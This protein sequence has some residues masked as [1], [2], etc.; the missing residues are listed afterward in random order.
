MNKIKSLV[1]GL[2]KVGLHYDLPNF[3]TCLSHCNSLNIHRKFE[4]VGGVDTNKNSRN[5]FENKFRK[6]SFKNIKYAIQ[7]IRPNLIILSTPTIKH[8]ENIKEIIQN[9][10][11][12]LKYLVLEKPLSYSFYEAKEI[13]KICNQNKV[14]FFINYPYMHETFLKKIKL[15]IK[16]NIN[17]QP[18]INLTYSKG[19]HHIG[20]HLLKILIYFLGKPSKIIKINSEKNFDDFYFQ[21]I[22]KF[23]KI[24]VY[25]NY[26]KNINVANIEII[27]SKGQIIIDLNSL[28]IWKRL[29]FKKLDLNNYNVL[30][31]KFHIIKNSLNNAQFHYYNFLSKSLKHKKIIKSN[32]DEFFIEKL[33]FKIKN[34]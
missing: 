18:I 4:L 32:N 12:E 21:G 27:N 7:K 22:L 9:K 5:I 29:K 11:K 24:K 13:L 8:L 34:I 19:M 1:I 15:I 20:S 3:D 14:K 26:I 6:E 30:G 23:K 25:F 17:D 33:I 31:D 2:G 10:N 16:N 28:K